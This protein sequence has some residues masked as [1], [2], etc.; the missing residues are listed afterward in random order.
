[1]TEASPGVAQEQPRSS[2]EQPRSMQDP[3]QTNS[4]GRYD[5]SNAV[6]F[7]SGGLVAHPPLVH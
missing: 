7:A 1:M 5:E 4:D 6:T 2:R 3:L